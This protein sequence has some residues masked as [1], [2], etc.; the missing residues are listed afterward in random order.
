MSSKIYALA[1]IGLEVDSDFYKRP[2]DTNATVTYSYLKSGSLKQLVAN[3]KEIRVNIY[4]VAKYYKD[5]PNLTNICFALIANE[6]DTLGYDSDGIITTKTFEKQVKL[7]EAKIKKG[8][9]LW[10]KN[11]TTIPL[12]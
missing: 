3:Y 11:T 5:S 7:I 1:A 12:T 8:V 6:L 9:Y 2:L 10:K 4:S